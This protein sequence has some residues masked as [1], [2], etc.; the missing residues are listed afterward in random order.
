VSKQD[1][2]AVSVASIRAETDVISIF[3][4]RPANPDQLLPPFEAGAHIDIHLANGLVRS[5][6]LLN[7][8]GEQHRYVIGVNLDAKSR[9]GSRHLHES[10]C[11]GD[12]L[13]ISAPRN[14]FRLDEAAAH[15]VLFAGGIGI[16]PLWSMIQRLD[17]I[18]RTWTLHYCARSRRSA[19]LAAELTSLAPRPGCAVHFHFDDEQGGAL[20]DLAAKVN[21]EPLA[22]H[23]YCCGP[24]PM[25]GAFEHATAQ[26]PAA[27]VHVEYFS[28][29]SAPDRAGG[30]EVVLAK[31]NRVL[32][33]EPGKTILDAV[34][35]AG[36]DVP[37]ACCEGVCGSC[38]VTVLE[39]KPDHHD[40]V[41]TRDEQAANN[42]MLICCS[43]AKSERLVLDI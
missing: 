3:E 26:C 35:A 42:Q 33:I 27:N 31:S 20:L 1:T 8:Q 7:A 18:G 21:A 14:N 43:G 6:S 4:L 22:T 28:A 39:G 25:L 37:Y 11:A 38:L 12:S 10:V 16:T 15:T 2:I 41:L 29:K 19:A 34:L 5:Y 9:G 40:L 30:F 36:V 32:R 23:F 24:V 17:S 13:E